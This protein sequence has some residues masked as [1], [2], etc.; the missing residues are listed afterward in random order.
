[1]PEPNDTFAEALALYIQQMREAAHHDARRLLFMDWVRRVFGI[2]LNEFQV[3]ERV[4][5]GRVDAILGSLV[6]EFKS[7]LPGE[8]EDAQSQLRRY[9]SGLRETRA[10]ATY[11]AIATDGLRFHVY[12]PRYAADGVTVT[13]LEPL[14]DVDLENTSLEPAD[15][16]FRFDALLSHFRLDRRPATAQSV[17]AGLGPASATFRAARI[18]LANLLKRS[19]GDP[20][21]QVRFQE[22]QRYLALV[23]GESLGDHELFL[24]HTYLATVARLVALFHVQPSATFMGDADVKD[25]VRGYYFSDRAGLPNFI[26]EDFF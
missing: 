13:D 10:K 15:L 3:E 19:D 25:V 12:A 16:F 8:L 22:W 17:V 2:D 21:V 20:A 4:Y 7:D 1:M 24:K 26:E 6:F 9:I 18:A 14:W 23:Y 5:Q 11:T